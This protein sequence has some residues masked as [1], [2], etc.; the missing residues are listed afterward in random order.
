MMRMILVFRHLV[1]LGAM[2]VGLAAS[3][4]CLGGTPN[5]PGPN[6]LSS[7]TAAPLPRPARVNH[8]RNETFSAP[9]PTSLSLLAVGLGAIAIVR[10]RR[11]WFR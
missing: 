9:E 2:L 10:K 4:A 8:P 6:L 1:I 11:Q 7:P 3:T 5:D